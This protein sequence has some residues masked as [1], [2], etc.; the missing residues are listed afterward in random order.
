MNVGVQQGN[1]PRQLRTLSDDI[2]FFFD[3]RSYS[4]PDRVVGRGSIGF[5]LIRPCPTAIR[6]MATEGNGVADGRFRYDDIAK[7]INDAL[8]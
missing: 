7:N 2:V 6:R 4:G 1:E 8:E 5:L 3:H